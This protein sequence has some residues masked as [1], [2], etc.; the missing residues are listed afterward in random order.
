[1]PA[2]EQ[3]KK[4][5]LIVDDEPGIVAYLETLL[6]DNGYDTVSATDGRVGFEKLKSERPD[7]VTLDITMPVESGIRFYRDMKDDP[8]FAAVPVV[9]VTAVTGK[10]GNPEE[11]KKFISTRKQVPPPDGFVAKPVDQGELLALV[12]KLLP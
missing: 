5:I 6:Q 8:E 1:M 9:I 7:L 2:N 10:G 11:F 3:A 12:K 4:K